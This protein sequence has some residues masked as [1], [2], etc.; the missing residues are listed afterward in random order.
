MTKNIYIYSFLFKAGFECKI[1][2][3]ICVLIMWIQKTGIKCSYSSFLV[4]FK[5]DVISY[6]FHANV[7]F[8][9]KRFETKT[10]VVLKEICRGFIKS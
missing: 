5:G 4:Y 3:W 6:L 9:S 2:I 7:R 8:F 1:T 10:Q